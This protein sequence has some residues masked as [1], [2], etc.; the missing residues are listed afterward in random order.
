MIRSMGAMHINLFVNGHKLS[1]Y[2]CKVTFIYRRSSGMLWIWLASYIGT[3]SD[4]EMK[5]RIE[6]PGVSVR[7]HAGLNQVKD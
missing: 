4:N 3:I 1:R 5:N 2:R 7:I 6:D